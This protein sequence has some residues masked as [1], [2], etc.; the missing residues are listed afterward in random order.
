MNHHP[1]PRLLLTATTLLLTTAASHASQLTTFETVVPRDPALAGSYWAPNPGLTVDG[2]GFSGGFYSGFVVSDATYLTGSGYLFYGNSSGVAEISAYTLPLGGGVAGSTNYAVGYGSSMINLPVGKA[3]AWVY[4][5]NT[6]TAFYSMNDG[7][8]FAK[9]FG[10]STG[11]DPDFFEVIF[12]G[13][14]GQDATGGTTGSVTFRLADFTFSDNS[15]D[16]IVQQWTLVDLTPL[17]SA[18][19]IQLS[20]AS[21]DVGAFGINTPTYVALDNLM[22]IPEPTSG[23][24]LAMAG[25]VMTLRRRRR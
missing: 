20:F 6:T 8:M 13:Y 17:G 12:T 11:N 15:L 10:G 16:Y 23:L 5:T 21:S 22:L 18:S 24:L 19:S 25:A 2:I 1:I 14:T 3:A 4:V 9:K 7:D